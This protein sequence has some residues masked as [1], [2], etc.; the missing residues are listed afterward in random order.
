MSGAGDR[1]TLYGKPGCHLCDDARAV[2]SQVCAELGVTW[3]EIDITQDD[4][5]FAEYGEQIPVTFVDG[6]QHDFWRVDPV[7]LKLALTS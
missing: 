5:L 7:R 1:V 6:A 2:V 3:S 4:R